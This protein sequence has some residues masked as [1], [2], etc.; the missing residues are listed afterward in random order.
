MLG[1]LT[2][3]VTGLAVHQQMLNVVGDNLA[4]VN[5]TA[6][7]SQSIQFSDLLPRTLQPGTT[8]S[9]STTSGTNPFQIGSGAQVASVSTNHQQR[10]I[11][12]TGGQLDLAIQGNG[13]FQVSSGQGALYTRAGAFA[14][15]Q[16]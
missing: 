8:S 1:S 6:F 15:D 9:S 3:G 10:A 13:Y 4:N 12:Q 16:N 14:L 2:A 5:T 7:K 11:T